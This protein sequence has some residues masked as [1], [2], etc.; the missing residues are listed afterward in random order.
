[1]WASIATKAWRM[2]YK[3]NTMPI[4]KSRSKS[5]TGKSSKPPKPS[6]ST[7]P[8]NARSTGAANV[9]VTP[10]GHLALKGM[11]PAYKGIPPGWQPRKSKK[12]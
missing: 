7:A 4:N 12:P 3:E 9:R 2:G 1:M 11:P 8:K 10:S 6:A 5:A